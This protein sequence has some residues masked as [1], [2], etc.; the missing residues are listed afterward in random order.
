MTSLDKR[1]SGFFDSTLP[2]NDNLQLSIC[3]DLSIAEKS[4]I[5]AIKEFESSKNYKDLCA[6][7]LDVAKRSQNTLKEIYRLMFINNSP[8]NESSNENDDKTIVN[9][10]F[11]E[12]IEESE[13]FQ[14]FKN[15]FWETGLFIGYNVCNDEIEARGKIIRLMDELDRTDNELKNE[16]E[17][18]KTKQNYWYLIKNKVMAFAKFIL[19]PHRKLEQYECEIAED[20]LSNGEMVRGSKNHIVQRTYLGC[21]KVAETTIGQ[22]HDELFYELKNEIKFMHDLHHP[23]LDL[24]DKLSIARGIASA[25]DYCHERHILHY[26]VKT[27]NVLLDKN[28]HPRLYNFRIAKEF[29]VILTSSS[30]ALSTSRWSSPERIRGEKYDKASEVYSFALVMW[31]IEY[32]NIPFADF[33]SEDEI[34]NQVLCGSR[35]ELTS[36]DGILAK[37]HEIIENSWSQD[38]SLRPDMRTIHEYLNKPNFIYFSN[39]DADDDD[40]FDS[41]VDTGPSNDTILKYLEFENRCQ[42]G[43]YPTRSDKIE[44]GIKY[45]QKKKHK[46]AWETF[47]EWYNLHSDDSHANFWLGFYYLKGYH[48]KKNDQTS[49]KYLKKASE[50]Q[51]PDAQYWYAYILLN[52]PAVFNGDRYAIALKHLRESAMQNHRLAL[53]K[54][55]RIVQLGSYRQERDVLIGKTMICIADQ[56]KMKDRKE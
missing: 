56:M 22:Y 30:V 12:F 51:H 35:P 32:Q 17:N 9:H 41:I 23:D 48:V 40:Y 44:E 46:Q 38:P 45:H 7:G 2:Q 24:A 4:L 53:K 10:R 8:S 42:S 49:M 47:N 55:G 5:F 15:C 34:T 11:Q 25:L 26:D 28:L 21:I 19:I 20:H 52:G 43:E 13:T 1:E 6:N 18:W 50:L 29:P 27:D 3:K 36:A 14:K 37:Y 16:I 39:Q 33:I 54:L 31:A